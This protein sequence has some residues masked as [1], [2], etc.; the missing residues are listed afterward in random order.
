VRATRRVDITTSYLS[1]IFTALSNSGHAQPAKAVLI[2]QTATGTS[3]LGGRVLKPLRVGI[4]HIQPAKAVLTTDT[5]SRTI[6]QVDDDVNDDASEDSHNS[7]FTGLAEDSQSE[8]LLASQRPFIP[9]YQDMIIQ[10]RVFLTTSKSGHHQ[11][12]HRVYRLRKKSIP[13]RLTETCAQ[14]GR[15][16]ALY[17]R[18]SFTVSFY[19]TFQ[20]ITAR[21]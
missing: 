2:R 5:A 4:T 6:H 1:P 3:F 10:M 17:S 9:P 20:T 11:A 7:T 12:H 8:T 15:L 13:T 19:C 16:S 18:T 21:W 14:T